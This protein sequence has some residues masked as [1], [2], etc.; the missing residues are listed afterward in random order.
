MVDELSLKTIDLILDVMLPVNIYRRGDNSEIRGRKT[1]GID[2]RKVEL[3]NGFSRVESDWG[4]YRL[5]FNTNPRPMF[6]LKL[7]SRQGHLA[8]YEKPLGDTGTGERRGENGEPKRV[9]SNAPVGDAGGP[10]QGRYLIGF[11]IGALIGG[12][13]VVITL[14]PRRRRQG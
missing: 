14:W 5:A 13:M 6:G 3:D 1:A 7:V 11:G 9:V 4:A 8:A 2:K 10:F 12:G